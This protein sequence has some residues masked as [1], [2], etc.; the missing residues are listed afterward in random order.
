ME[1]KTNKIGEIKRFACELCTGDILVEADHDDEFTPNAL[2]RIQEEFE[3]DY[4]KN[5]IDFVKTEYQNHTCF[6]KGDNIFSAFDFSSSNSF[7]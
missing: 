1:K 4:F 5:L 7:T 3:K 6:P 2:E